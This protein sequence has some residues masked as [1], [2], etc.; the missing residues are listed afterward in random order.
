ME[1]NTAIRNY[2]VVSYRC[3]DIGYGVESGVVEG[4]FTGEE[5]AW[6][7]LTLQCNNGDVLYLFQDEI[8]AIDAPEE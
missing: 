1:N 8:C 7:K 2:C 6:G 4:Y 3:R 5:D